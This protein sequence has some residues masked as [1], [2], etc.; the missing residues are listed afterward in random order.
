MS[1]YKIVFTTNN[2]LFSIRG[3]GNDVSR[4][5]DEVGVH[6]A[7]TNGSPDGRGGAGTASSQT[8]APD[9]GHT[10]C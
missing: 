5:P 6:F 4:L 10:S 7:D 3:T 8:C 1:F 2:E 9:A